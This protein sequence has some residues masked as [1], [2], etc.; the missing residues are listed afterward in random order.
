MD[1]DRFAS[2]RI[3]P[4]DYG[5][6]CRFTAWPA[7]QITSLVSSFSSAI[8]PLSSSDEEE[9]EEELDTQLYGSTISRDNDAGFDQVVFNKT[10]QLLAPKEYCTVSGLGPSGCEHHFPNHTASRNYPEKGET[11]RE[12]DGQAVQGKLA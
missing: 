9:E 3:R 7:S 8:T 6:C 11:T 5:E 4:T 1:F 10:K 12:N 2:R